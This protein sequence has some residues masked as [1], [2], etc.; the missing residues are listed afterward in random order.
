MHKM[1]QPVKKCR[2]Q[3]KNFQEQDKMLRL[4][5]LCNTEINTYEVKSTI[6]R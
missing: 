2:D 4:S 1:K 6:Y 3:D 5:L